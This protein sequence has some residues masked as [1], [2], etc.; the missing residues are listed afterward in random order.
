MLKYTFGFIIIP[1]SN[2]MAFTGVTNAQ[3]TLTLA[4]SMQVPNMQ[5]YNHN[6]K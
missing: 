1:N 4:N 6:R 3:W 2:L 5:S